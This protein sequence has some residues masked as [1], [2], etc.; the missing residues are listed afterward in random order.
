M[1][2]QAGCVRNGSHMVVEIG[3]QVPVV[4][5]CGEVPPRLGLGNQL[6][7]G[8]GLLRGRHGDHPRSRG[9]GSGRRTRGLNW[10]RRGT[11]GRS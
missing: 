5:G 6:G 9:R 11:H 3:R 2:R 8:D 4:A 10:R 7:M 1:R